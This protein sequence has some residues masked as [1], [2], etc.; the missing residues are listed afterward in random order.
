M[1]RVRSI[2]T[3][4]LR[5]GVSRTARACAQVLGRAAVLEGRM[6]EWRVQSEAVA[7]EIVD[8]WLLRVRRDAWPSTEG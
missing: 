4:L 6:A 1:I 3:S 2:V 5:L 8:A 7:L